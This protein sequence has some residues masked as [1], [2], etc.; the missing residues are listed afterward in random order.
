MSFFKASNDDTSCPLLI[1]EACENH[2]GNLDAAL[3]MIDMAKKSGCDIIKFQHHLPE[4]EMLPGL[5]MSDNFS[6]DLFD[7]LKRCSLSLDQHKL[8]YSYCQEVGIQYLCTPFCKEA[9]IDLVDNN[10][11][12]VIKIGSGE[13]TDFPLI[14]YLINSRK[15]LLI[16]TG[17]STWSEID[18]L[19]H[20][21]KSHNAIFAIFH[22][23]SEYPPLTN[24]LALDTLSALRSR[25]PGIP[26]GYSCHSRSIYPAIASV[27][28]RPAF[29]EKHVIINPDQIC[30][31]QSV[32]ITFDDMK[33]LSRAI[34]E[35]H[36][37]LGQ[38]SGVYDREKDIR[39]WA[40][41]VVVALTPISK[42]DIITEKN[43]T[44]MRAGNS[45]IPASQFYHLLNK[46]A[47]CDISALSPITDQIV[48]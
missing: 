38:R 11:G 23:V 25:Y 40:R 36:S 20:F 18:E 15:K 37:A 10:L 42:G 22:C 47:L 39:D 28:Y 3:S 6:E 45:G 32:S 1:A 5:K 2:L 46:T 13:M 12:D 44:T 17:M 48:Q 34:K 33:N 21:L 24:D 7:F 35:V 19:V 16:S 27:V 4:K 29:I 26:I 8:L 41:H 31:D 30:P 14:Q 9:A 43:I